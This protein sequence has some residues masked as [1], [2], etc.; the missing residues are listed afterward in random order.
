MAK[1]PSFTISEKEIAT[2]KAKYMP[3]AGRTNEDFPCE[4]HKMREATA[5]FYEGQGHKPP[6][7]F[8]VGP[9]SY[10]KERVND[11]ITRGHVREWYRDTPDAAITLHEF[12]APLDWKPTTKDNL[13]A[14]RRSSVMIG[15]F[16]V[17]T[18]SLVEISELM[19]PERVTHAANIGIKKQF[20]EASF[21][22]C[23]TEACFMAF[24]PEEIIWPEVA[25]G[26]VSVPEVKDVKKGDKLKPPYTFKEGD[27]LEVL[28]MALSSLKAT[29][30]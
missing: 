17:D 29:E 30:L 6:T 7:V 22:Y 12:K 4:P 19:D 20:E 8:V 5:K 13:A 14:V 16:S 23:F 21:F 26:E 11:F 1:D 24:R 25:P 27:S 15:Q 28:E 10:I 2:I 9:H 3:Y 18:R